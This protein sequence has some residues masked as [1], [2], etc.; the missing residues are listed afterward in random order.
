MFKIGYD[1]KITMVQG[2]TGVIRMRISNYELSQGDEVRFAIANKANP[3]ILL[4]QHSDKKIVLEKQVTVFERDGSARIV[5]YPYDTEYLQPGK[6]LYEIQVKTKDGRIDTVVPLTSFT[7]MDGSIQGEYGQTTPSKPE[8]TPSEIELRFKRLENEIIPELGNRI[9]NVENEIDSVNSSLDDIVININKF[10]NFKEALEFCSN[11]KCTLLINKDIDVTEQIEITTN[12]PI[13][14]KGN[15]LVNFNNNNNSEF[16]LK[17]NT[18]CD[19]EISKGLTFNFNNSVYNG[20]FI[21]NDDSE[22]KGNV[23]I[24]CTVKNVCRSGKVFNGGN[25]I[26]C[27]GNFKNIYFNGVID[28]V[29]MAKD[30]G[31]MSSQGITG[32]TVSP[33]NELCADIV[34]IGDKAEINKITSLDSSYTYD[35]D[36][37]KVFG[38]NTILIIEKGA[39]FTD[40]RGRF[41]KTQNLKSYI[42]GNYN[43]INEYPSHGGIDLQYGNGVLDGVIINNKTEK[44]LS[45]VVM[46][47]CN[48]TQKN[49]SYIKYMEV[50]S[51]STISTLI[52]GYNRNSL[53]VDDLVIDN[54]LVNSNIDTLCTF[55]AVGEN[56]VEITNTKIKN[57]NNLLVEL[58]GVDGANTNVKIKNVTNYGANEP[59][60]LQH[61]ISGNI[62]RGKIIESNNIIGFY[63][64][65]TDDD[66]IIDGCYYPAPKNIIGSLNNR[67]FGGVKPSFAQISPSDSYAFPI[68]GRQDYIT[69]L[70][71]INVVNSNSAGIYYVYKGSIAPIFE[72]N[73]ST[74]GETGDLSIKSENGTLVVTN[75]TTSN[76]QVSVTFI[77]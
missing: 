52:H 35:Q 36:G 14:I 6:Y 39:S 61:R 48:R 16:G 66:T 51:T 17:I 59:M 22:I 10:N 13:I 26:W 54:I 74:T 50:Y 72:K 32:F 67:S 70:A 56:T 40:C 49:T 37:L 65:Y 64:G 45:K 25:G 57:L 11:N 33:Y 5:I 12:I 41:L 20:I 30:A 19:V 3:S 7:L 21:L 18:N 43:M 38:D 27:R 28:G 53:P 44:N 9:T 1:K 58:K 55:Y 42:S 75:L 62:T 23:N 24:E 47:G 71:I 60:L 68:I 2:D 76:K 77:G 73:I 31:V 15:G 4:C 29:F 8:P 34:K 46:I 69:Y 63:N